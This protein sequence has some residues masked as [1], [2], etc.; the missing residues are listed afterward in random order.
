MIEI[1]RGELEFA[2][3]QFFGVQTHGGEADEEAVGVSGFQGVPAIQKAGMRAISSK[4]AE[5]SKAS[6]SLSICGRLR[7][8]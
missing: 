2:H 4:V 5:M 8:G 7:S 1:E 3:T 6:I